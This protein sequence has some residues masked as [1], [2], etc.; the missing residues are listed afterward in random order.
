M[1]SPVMTS[2]YVSLPAIQEVLFV[3]WA[4]A[5]GNAHDNLRQIQSLLAEGV[6]SAAFVC[7]AAT[8]D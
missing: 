1:R 4:F 7:Q 5:L 2:A 6:Y 3:N 8:M